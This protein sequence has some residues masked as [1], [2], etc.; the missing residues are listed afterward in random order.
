MTKDVSVSEALT[1]EDRLRLHVHD[2]LTFGFVLDDAEQLV[3]E[4]DA[5][6]SNLKEQPVDP[7]AVFA[8]WVSQG[9]KLAKA[10][11]VYVGITVYDKE[12]SK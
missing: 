5:L 7:S 1:A 12:L 3:A 6:R 4:I 9:P 8:E 10:A 11:G 2:P